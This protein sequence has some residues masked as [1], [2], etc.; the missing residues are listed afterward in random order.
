MGEKEEFKLPRFLTL[1]EEELIGLILC[2]SL[3]VAEY[4]L[5][6]LLLPVAGDLIDIAGVTFCIYLFR[7]AGAISLLE[8]VPGLDILPIYLI[9]WLTWYYMKKVEEMRKRETH[10]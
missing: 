9:T 4:I 1:T 3:D 6:V 2:I 10:R 7:W 8:F 5:K